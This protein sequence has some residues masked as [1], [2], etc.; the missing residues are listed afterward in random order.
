MNENFGKR[1]NCIKSSVKSHEKITWTDLTNIE[2]NNHFSR[3]RYYRDSKQY[4]YCKQPIKACQKKL[5]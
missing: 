5:F 3:T 2:K 1:C 4:Q